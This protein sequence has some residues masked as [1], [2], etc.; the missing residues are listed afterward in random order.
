M[1][2]WQR[3][4]RSIISLPLHYSSFNVLMTRICYFKCV[5]PSWRPVWADKH[6]CFLRCSPVLKIKAF[7]LSNLLTS[8]LHHIERLKAYGPQ[9]CIYTFENYLWYSQCNTILKLEITP[10]YYKTIFNSFEN[11][12]CFYNFEHK[13][14]FKVSLNDTQ[15][16]QF[17][18]SLLRV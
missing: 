1:T 11:M 7:N 10:F 4:W 15:I 14:M 6:W 16:K 8:S 13:V 3:N 9:T 17:S 12:L 5:K 2:Y 18:L